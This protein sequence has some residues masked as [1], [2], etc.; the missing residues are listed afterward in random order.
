M[1]WLA[2]KL[3]FYS[4][5]FLKYQNIWF[6]KCF[7]LICDSLNFLRKK[8]CIETSLAIQRKGE[9]TQLS[10]ISNR[11][12]HAES[13]MQTGG[14]CIGGKG[15]IIWVEGHWETCNGVYL[16]QIKSSFVFAFHFY[17]GVFLPFF[18]VLFSP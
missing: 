18:L 12:D 9:K 2:K 13:T 15:N 8:K 4:S 11:D 1:I 17:F 3:E 14:H 5:I 7:L 10:N 16:F 6:K